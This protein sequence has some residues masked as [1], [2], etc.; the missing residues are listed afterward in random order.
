[1]GNVV[2]FFLFSLFL[3]GVSGDAQV[4]SVKVGDSVT[5]Q[6]DSQIQSGDVIFWRFQP[7]NIMIASINK[8]KASFELNKELDGNFKSRLQL[9]VQSGYLTIKNIMTTDSGDYEVSNDNGI[10]KSFKVSVVS[11]DFTKTVSV[12]EGDLVTL[13]TDVPDIKIYDAIEW[14]FEYQKSPVA[15]I[16]AGNVPKYDETD[17]RFKDRLQLDPQTA[18]LTIKNIRTELAGLYKAD[19]I[20]SGHTVHKSYNVI[21]IAPRVPVC[22]PSG[23]SSGAVA[24]I[25]VCLL[26]LVAVAVALVIYYRRKIAV[27]EKSLNRDNVLVPKPI[28][29][30]NE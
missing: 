10:K 13:H 11:V 3:E 21:V 17:T 29:T 5:L 18:S 2:L 27:L 28:H 4:V 14:R 26:L 30:N 16:K 19:I 20:S 6:T 15:E 7:Q 25:V 9:R 22:G 8:V 12:L 23:W 1:M 24:G